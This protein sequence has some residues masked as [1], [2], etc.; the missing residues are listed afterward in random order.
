GPL[1][2]RPGEP[3]RGDRGRI[4]AQDESAYLRRILLFLA[5]ADGGRQAEAG[6]RR[7]RRAN[8]FLPARHTGEQQGS[9]KAL[10]GDEWH[11]YG[12]ATRFGSRRGFSLDPARIHRPAGQGETDTAGELHR[13]RPGPANAGSGTAEPRADARRNVR[14]L[15]PGRNRAL[16]GSYTAEVPRP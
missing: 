2:R 6:L 14:S 10:R 12:R 9:E 1:D 7:S 8:L 4:R 3:G 16:A 11:Q 15:R 5:R 13:S